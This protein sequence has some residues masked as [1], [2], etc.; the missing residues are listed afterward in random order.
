M[1]GNK[2]VPEEGPQEDPKESPKEAPM[3]PAWVGKPKQQAN[4]G[5]LTHAGSIWTNYSKPETVN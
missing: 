1:N 2:S 4:R 3:Q 5:T